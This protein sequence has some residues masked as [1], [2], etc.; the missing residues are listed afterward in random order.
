[1]KKLKLSFL[2]AGLA[3]SI[4]APIPAQA[5]SK[6]TILT[7]AFQKYLT[8]GE[9]NYSKA[10]DLAK[11]LFEPKIAAAESKIVAAR[12]QFRNVNQATVIMVP[13]RLQTDFLTFSGL[14]V[15]SRTAKT[16]GFDDCIPKEIR[17]KPTSI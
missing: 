2:V 14:C 9:V 16:C 15:R 17:L 8:D 3:I 6:A 12:T 7:K 5:A 1:M 11:N 4:S 13:T 10:M